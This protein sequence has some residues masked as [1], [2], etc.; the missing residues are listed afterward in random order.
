MSVVDIEFSFDAILEEH[1]E[2]L[3]MIDELKH[4]LKSRRPELGEE[5]ART[6][7][8]NLSELLVKM[9][10][11]LCAHFREEE[12]TKALEELEKRHPQAA[13]EI[14]LLRGEHEEIL[15][16]VRAILGAAMVYAG[17]KPP[18]S[19]HLRR[20]TLAVLDRIL[21]HE[22]QESDLISKA[23]A[24]TQPEEVLDDEL[25]KYVLE[26]EKPELCLES[27][28]VPVRSIGPNPAKTLPVGST[29]DEAIR[30]VQQGGTSCVVITRN[31]EL[32]G[33]IT[34]RDL[35]TRILGKGLDPTKVT[36]EEVMTRELFTLRPGEPLT[37]ALSLMDTGGYR[38]VLI[39]D[40]DGR[41]QGV[42]TARGILNYVVGFFPE[43]VKVLPPSSHGGQA[44]ERFGA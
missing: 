24:T 42:V 33:L 4:F 6:W 34:E 19:P 25:D 3:R 1:R 40:E 23:I 28:H 16:D 31:G 39:V 37:D 22:R 43:D 18:E 13:G 41:L 27:F 32:A 9:H 7:A 17:G 44:A 12:E 36:V 30:I 2:L 10:D 29:V 8:S 35:V 20:W 11:K 14:Q 26:E 21:R 5:A 15:Y 38:H